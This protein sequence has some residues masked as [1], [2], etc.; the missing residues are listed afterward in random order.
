MT[1]THTQM[2]NL[3]QDLLL[4]GA[5]G[6]MTTKNK[7]PVT[8]KATSEVRISLYDISGVKVA[9]VMHNGLAEGEHDIV[10]D[11]RA[12]AIPEGNYVYQAEIT[13]TGGTEKYCRM[14]SV[15]Y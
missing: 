10:V 14:V 8:L 2:N 11:G 3:E 15:V 1:A 12:L 5:P 6:K 13:D 9:D 7:I 4:V